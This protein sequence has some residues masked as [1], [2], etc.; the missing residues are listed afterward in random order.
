LTLTWREEVLV[1]FQI[2]ILILFSSSGISNDIFSNA[3]FVM[4]FYFCV[5]FIYVIALVISSW[6][7]DLL[8]RIKTFVSLY[9]V[10]FSILEAFVYLSST[11]EI[12]SSAMSSLLNRPSRAFP[13][14]SSRLWFSV[15]ACISL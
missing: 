11:W 3:S 12:L 6:F 7:L 10:C 13:L 8:L 2:F 5:S 14:C 1:L 15:S 9:Y 4:F